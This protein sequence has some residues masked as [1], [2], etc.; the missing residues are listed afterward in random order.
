M[1][2][3]REKREKESVWRKE[4]EKIKGRERERER[5]ER[6]TRTNQILESLHLPCVIGTLVIIFISVK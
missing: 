4:G 2:V 6:S 3:E 1:C 5:E